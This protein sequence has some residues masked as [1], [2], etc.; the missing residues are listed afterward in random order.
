VNSVGASLAVWIL[1]SVLAW[2]G[3]SSFAEL[4]CAIPLNGGAQAYLGLAYNPLISYLF[5]WTAISVRTYTSHCPHFQTLYQ[6]LKPGSN[7]IIALVF[8]EYLTR[9]YFHS[10]GSA[11]AADELPG[12]SVKLTATAVIVLITLLNIATPN[13]STRAAV[14]LTGLKVRPNPMI[15]SLDIIRKQIISL[16]SLGAVLGSSS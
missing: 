1:G 6:A 10:T 2:T 3:A 7:A 16:V 9:L 13:S 11:V 4:G 12:W 8:G 5:A 14:G 15:S